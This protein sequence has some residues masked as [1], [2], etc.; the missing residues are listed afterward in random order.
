ME[1]INAISGYSSKLQMLKRLY[2]EVYSFCQLVA[3]DC[4]I[5]LNLV[6]YTRTDIWLSVHVSSFGNWQAVSLLEG[7]SRLLGDFSSR[8]CVQYN[9]LSV[10]S[11]TSYNSMTTD[12]I[13]IKR[14]AGEFYEWISRHINSGY[15][16]TKN[17][18][19]R[20]RRLV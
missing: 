2:R 9:A 13:F 17:N 7:I 11:K 1:T 5:Y 19:H 10:R 8:R 14:N 20:T 6:F 16:R 18:G 15:N 4:T 3:T 12:Q